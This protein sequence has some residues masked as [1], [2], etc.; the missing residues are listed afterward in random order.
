MQLVRYVC[1]FLIYPS[2]P[3]VALDFKYNFIYSMD[4]FPLSETM[5]TMATIKFESCMYIT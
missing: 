5:A 4:I 3:K 2:W 1:A